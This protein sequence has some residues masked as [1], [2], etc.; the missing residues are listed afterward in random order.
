MFSSFT[1]VQNDLHSTVS[2]LNIL[3]ANLLP[4]GHRKEGTLLGTSQLVMSLRLQSA[5]WSPGEVTQAP[6][7]QGSWSTVFWKSGYHIHHLFRF[8]RTSV[9]WWACCKPTIPKGSSLFWWLKINTHTTS[10]SKQK[11][12]PCKNVINFPCEIYLS[13]THS[14]END[15]YPGA[16]AEMCAH[17]Q[18]FL[19]SLSYSHIFPS[20]FL[21]I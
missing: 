14:E 18:A 1:M 5:I 12:F 8:I 15:L 10:A 7:L 20:H 4:R 17:K 6:Q 11:S 3:N 9:Q 19:K 16:G 2:A 13:P 21:I